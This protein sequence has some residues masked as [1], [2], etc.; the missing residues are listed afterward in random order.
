MKPHEAKARARI[1][2]ALGHPARMLIIEELSRG[3]RCGCELLPLLGIDQSV[4]S[5][6]LAYLKNAGIISENKDGVRVIYH[7]ACPCVLRALECTLGV[8]K[9]ESERQRKLVAKAEK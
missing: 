1:L 9:A 6:H 2:K 5:R 7:L 4:V 8:L 3:D